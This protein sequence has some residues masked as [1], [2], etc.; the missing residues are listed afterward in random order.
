MHAHHDKAGI[1]TLLQVD[2]TTGFFAAE[3]FGCLTV[4]PHLFFTDRALR[5]LR[6]G[7]L[8]FLGTLQLNPRH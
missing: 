1:L 7:T 4:R 8:D 5:E 3:L 6:K 2:N